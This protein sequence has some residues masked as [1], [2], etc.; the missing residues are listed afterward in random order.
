MNRGWTVLT[1]MIALVGCSIH[2]DSVQY[3]PGSSPRLVLE[4]DS[5]Q[6][7][8]GALVIFNWWQT[9]ANLAGG[10][11][12]CVRADFRTTDLQGRFEIPIWRGEYPTVVDV[13]KPGMVYT[14]GQ[15][16]SGVEQVRK[17]QSAISQRYDEMTRTSARLLCEDGGKHMLPVQQALLDEALAIRAAQTEQRVIDRF[18]VARD[19]AR[20][21]REEANRLYDE[22]LVA[23]KRG[24]AQ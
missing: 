1:S 20:Y 16:E 15:R 9:R 18:E 2:L 23:R 11:S 10:Q 21:G 19:A 3:P 24:A 6:P 17:S 8:A 4:A 5:Q 7:V 12:H 13:Y 22:R 14:G